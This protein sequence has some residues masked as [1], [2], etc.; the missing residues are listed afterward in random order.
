ME[1]E[2]IFMLNKF[3]AYRKEILKAY[4]NDDEFQSLCEDYFSASQSYESLKRKML[5]D[6]KGELEYR[7]LFLELEKEILEFLDSKKEGKKPR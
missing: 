1:V 4:T 2:V 7:E 5:K 3:P 6:Y